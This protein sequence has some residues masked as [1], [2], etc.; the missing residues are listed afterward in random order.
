MI[1][2]GETEILEGDRSQCQFG[3]R[4]YPTL[5]ALRANANFCC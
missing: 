3:R 1:F 2:T 5:T 4:K